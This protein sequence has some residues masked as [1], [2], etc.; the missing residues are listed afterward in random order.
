MRVLIANDQHWPMVSGVATAA[1]TLAHALVE[2]GH[3][4]LVVAGS[5][6]GRRYKEVDINYPI[7]R[8]MS[9][10]VPFRDNYRLSIPM[11]KEVKKIV[12]EFEP[13]VIHVH[14]Q[15][16]VGIAAIKVATKLGIPLVAT[17]HA[18]PDNFVQH[19]KSLKPLHRPISYVVKEY[20]LRPYK[21]VDH[22]IMPTQSA[23]SMFEDDSIAVPMTPVSNGI[24][25]SSF[26]PGKVPDAFNK[27]YNLPLDDTPL[28][29]YVGRLD[30]EK[31]IQIMIK[32]LAKAMKKTPVHGL[33][34]GSG[35]VEEYLKK[36]VASLGVEDKFTF[37][38]RVSEEDLHELHRAAD[39]FVMPS[40][41]E[42]QCLA[43]LESMA[44]GK[45]VIAVNVS[46][47]PELC[48]DGRNGYLVEVD[49]VDDMSKKISE[50]AGDVELRGKMGKESLEIASEH[51]INTVIKKFV[52]I[53]QQAI[54]SPHSVTREPK[55]PLAK[56]IISR[57][58][59]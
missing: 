24:D 22:I 51:D 34:I 15:Y 18:M 28:V 32:A 12:E 50:L 25:L 58:K 6:T 36:L 41:A 45:P 47:L 7:I 40:P 31:R 19:F 46:A 10:G 55:K 59:R 35:A 1:R 4:V 57:K 29:A 54:D 9:V 56:R 43:M 20:V 26:H 5:Q 53:Y 33:I 37:T 21:D 11:Y 49:D 39:I 23:V 30:G 48:Q 42:L 8:T 3:E 14:T 13:D 16:P 17:N 52:G 2:N 38:G 44:S 27:K